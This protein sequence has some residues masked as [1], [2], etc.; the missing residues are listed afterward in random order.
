ML[1][2]LKILTTLL[3]WITFTIPRE[4]DKCLIINLS[5][6]KEVYKIGTI[7]NK[8]RYYYISLKYSNPRK[9]REYKNPLVD[10]LA[11]KNP[12]DVS[13]NLINRKEIDKLPDNL[14]L[15]NCSTVENFSLGTAFKLYLEKE[16][17]WLIFDAQK[18]IVEE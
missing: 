8:G 7:A 5:D 4:I 13:Y 14:F 15:C 10:I 12:N 9:D 17:G 11:P 1:T 2:K 16:D 18:L 3:V 6:N